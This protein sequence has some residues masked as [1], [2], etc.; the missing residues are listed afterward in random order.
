MQLHSKGSKIVW[1][2][3]FNFEKEIKIL[4][5]VGKKNVNLL[6]PSLCL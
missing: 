1:F 4:V 5:E 3:Y 2:K 6:I